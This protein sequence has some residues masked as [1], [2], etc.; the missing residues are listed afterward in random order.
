MSKWAEYQNYNEFCDFV[1]KL[2]CTNDEAERNIKL[3]LLTLF[4][5]LVTLQMIL[6]T[7]LILLVR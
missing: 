5:H 7:Q 6:L 1:M 4:L 2:N 3:L